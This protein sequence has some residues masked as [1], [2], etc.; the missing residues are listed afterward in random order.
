MNIIPDDEDYRIETI[1][2]ELVM[3]TTGQYFGEWGILEKKSRTAAAY[4]L[5][6]T[7]LFVIDG[8]S[9]ESSFGVIFMYILKLEMHDQS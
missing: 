6:D 3:L 2:K 8:K 4:T 1:E 9:F 5:E 7:D